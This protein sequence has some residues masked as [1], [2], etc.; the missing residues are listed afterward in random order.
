MALFGRKSQQT[1]LPDE[2]NQYYAAQRRER[3]GVAFMLGLFAL[4]AT[5][6][7]GLGVF[8]GGR[9]LYQKIQGDDKA[10]TP[11]V[12]QIDNGTG[13]VIL[14]EIAGNSVGGSNVTPGDQEVAPTTPT[15]TTPKT[16]TQTPSTGDDSSV[17]APTNPVTL[18]STGDEGH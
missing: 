2:V 17:N 10:K 12:V 13:K 4:I 8:F 11:A 16:P 1:I 15:Q 14:P 6:L 9:Y 5:L 18:P 7:V 3:T